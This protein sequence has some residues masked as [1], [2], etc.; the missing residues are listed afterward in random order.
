MATTLASSSAQIATFFSSLQSR[1]SRPS[2]S[3]QSHRSP[4]PTSSL[5]IISSKNPIFS[6]Y[7][8]HLISRR[9]EK[10]RAASQDILASEATSIE[11]SLQIVSTGDDSVSTVISVLLFVAFLGL[12]IL[13]IGVKYF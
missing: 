8:F 6:N 3:L 5:T 13:T 12:S 2:L 7:P 1:A 11:T 9:R 4:P 10:I